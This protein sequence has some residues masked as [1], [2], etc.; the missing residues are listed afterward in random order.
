MV[1]LLGYWA[2]LW[3]NLTEGSQLLKFLLLEGR[4]F[5]FLSLSSYFHGS[6][7]PGRDMRLV[8]TQD[9]LFIFKNQASLSLMRTIFEPKTWGEN[10]SS[11]YAIISSYTSR[12]IYHYFHD[13]SSAVRKSWIMKL[14]PNRLEILRLLISDKILSLYQPK[15]QSGA[16]KTMH[17]FAIF[18]FFFA[19]KCVKILKNS[20]SNPCKWFF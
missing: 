4:F 3:K 15:Y 13:S 17:V 8:V 1:L 14:V 19:S 2:G 7:V 20:L 12:F 9:V 11:L 5:L 18:F 16:R 6:I 10:S